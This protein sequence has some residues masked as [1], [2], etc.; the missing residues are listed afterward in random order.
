MITTYEVMKVTELFLMKLQP[1]IIFYEF[2]TPTGEYYRDYD[3]SN[4]I[5]GENNILN[6]NAWIP[7]K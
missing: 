6:L 5:E 4:L 3:T 2:V 1:I 7:I